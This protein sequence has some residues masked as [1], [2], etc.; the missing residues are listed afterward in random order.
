MLI[1]PATASAA[2][3]DQGR[4]EGQIVNDTKNG[5]SVDNQEVILTT[6]LGDEEMETVSTTTDSDGFFRFSDL[7]TESGRGNRY[8]ARG[9]V[10]TV[11]Q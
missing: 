9:R 10:L 11:Y 2:E 3:I 4:I 8:F 6:Y 5:G 1:S 7:S